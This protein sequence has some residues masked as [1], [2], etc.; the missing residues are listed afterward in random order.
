VLV[1]KR[2]TSRHTATTGVLIAVALLIEST[3]ALAL[4]PALDVSQYAHKAWT[5]RD[6]F[7]KG[8]I[9]TIAQ[10]PDG[11]LWLGTVFGLLRFDGVRSVPWRL[12]SVQS[13]PSDDVESL[14]VT[15]DGSLWIGTTKGLVRWTGTNLTGYPQLQ[16]R[17]VLRLLEDHEGIVWAS[18]LDV[19]QARQAKICAI[20]RGSVQCDGKD[21]RLGDTI[22][23]LFEDRH[24]NL[25]ASVSD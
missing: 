23:A 6:G 11:Y 15:H 17:L 14:L 22:F 10:T 5:I 12:P 4:N 20:Q 13:L 18:T 21:G 2:R 19:G 3:P 1:T 9:N 8:I 16:G 24:L 25:W 7:S